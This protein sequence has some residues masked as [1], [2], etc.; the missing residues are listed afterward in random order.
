MV[1]DSTQ[2]VNNKLTPVELRG[3]TVAEQ[4]DSP[5]NAVGGGG[6]AA[7]GKPVAMLVLIASALRDGLVIICSTCCRKYNFCI[8]LGT[9]YQFRN[10][11]GIVSRVPRRAIKASRR[12]PAEMKPG[13][14]FEAA[15]SDLE[16]LPLAVSSSPS[17]Q[18]GRCRG[19]RSVSRWPPPPDSRNVRRPG[20]VGRRT[21]PESPR[22]RWP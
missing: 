12:F 6:S 9:R 18:A 13:R 11:T 7:S 19:T 3:S 10:E 20:P 22:E 16:S 15:G 17:N 5:G 2:G 4:H 14:E 21:V 8:N 1:S